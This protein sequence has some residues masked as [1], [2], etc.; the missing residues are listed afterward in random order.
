MLLLRGRALVMLATVVT[1]GATLPAAGQTLPYE[2]I[3]FGGG[4]VTIGGDVSATFSCADADAAETDRCP[5]DGGFFNYTDYEHSALRMLRVD[6]TAAVK[7]GKRL[8]V[9]GELR[10][11]NAGAPEPY[12]L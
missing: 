3:V 8:S 7:A 5:G 10:S 11:E 4:R 1:L 9:L 6:V 2:P 12:A